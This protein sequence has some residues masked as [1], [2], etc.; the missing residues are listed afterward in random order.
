MQRRAAEA[1]TRKEEFRLL[2]SDTWREEGAGAM[3]S[4]L[5]AVAA[6]RSSVKPR[7]AVRSVLSDIGSLGEGGK[8]DEPSAEGALRVRR[9]LRHF[10][11]AQNRALF[12]L[13]QQ[14]QKRRLPKSLLIQSHW[15]LMRE[16]QPFHDG[17]IISFLELVQGSARKAITFP[18]ELCKMLRRNRR[19]LTYLDWNLHALRDQVDLVNSCST[20]RSMTHRNKEGCSKCPGIL[21]KGELKIRAL[22]RGTGQ[23]I[24]TDIATELGL[25]T[26]DV[27]RNDSERLSLRNEMDAHHRVMMERLVLDLQ[28]WH[29]ASVALHRQMRR[30]RN[31]AKS[32]FY[33]R[34]RRLVRMKRELDLMRFHRVTMEEN[35]A[36]NYRYSDMLEESEEYRRVCVL[37]NN[38]IEK[39]YTAKLL[40]HWN[41][42][43][44]RKKQRQRQREQELEIV[45]A[46]ERQVRLE[47]RRQRLAKKNE[48]MTA[49]I[50]ERKLI[51]EKM[52]EKIQKLKNRVFKCERVDCRGRTFASQA[53]LDIHMQLH[54]K[55]DQENL[56]RLQKN[57]L[58]K[59]RRERMETKLLNR[60][61][62][63]RELS[64]MFAEGDGDSCP[65]GPF[66]WYEYCDVSVC[67]ECDSESLLLQIA[68]KSQSSPNN[69]LIEGVKTL[70]QYSQTC[71][72]D[73]PRDLNID[74]SDFQSR[75]EWLNI[76]SH[77][78]A[79]H[80][81]IR[82]AGMYLELLSRH[83]DVSAPFRIPLT[84]PQTRIGSSDDCNVICID[85][86]KAE[87]G[88]IA[89]IHA[90]IFSP[91]FDSNVTLPSDAPAFA[92]QRSARAGVQEM[93]EETAEPASLPASNAWDRTVLI[94]DNSSSFGTYVVS[95]G[96]VHKVPSITSG[97]IQ[98][99]SSGDLICLGVCERGPE[100]LSA[101]EASS[102]AVVFRVRGEN[103][104]VDDQTK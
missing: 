46:R 34:I 96:G 104:D 56:E 21:I 69:P 18:T 73:S 12:K 36:F 95:Y 101:V 48:E 71:T 43:S 9:P 74:T 8:D 57:A 27:E 75:F 68:E 29:C 77:L 33:Y 65:S 14:L 17:S 103:D 44:G 13:H 22:D 83:P 50:D 3:H 100:S 72:L 1:Q 70:Q 81:N 89:P 76:Q 97:R 80:S 99:L 79:V 38:Y 98:T 19:R 52:K 45:R 26:K 87:G 92:P 66:S 62:R 28:H 41:I 82:P 16:I 42:I 67:H 2:K 31:L 15:Y 4:L 20:C 51:V 88:R 49:S 35:E 40:K 91:M 102:A 37:R 25:L 86:S 54:F 6:Y 94:Y 30:E 63:I 78:G 53:R 60:I 85:K 58:N 39:K 5:S 93:K 23:A 10:H 7:L 59:H 24:I 90:I 55:A 47:R 84:I 64:A 11:Y 61:R 32:L